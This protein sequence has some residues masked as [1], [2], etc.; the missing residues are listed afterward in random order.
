MSQINM[1]WTE[2]GARLDQAAGSLSYTGAL[3]TT[4][5][6]PQQGPFPL[7]FL[8]LPISNPTLAR[9]EVCP[10]RFRATL[11]RALA[12]SQQGMTVGLE[13]D[14][15]LRRLDNVLQ[16]S[17]LVCGVPTAHHRELTH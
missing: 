16:Q 2:L 17:E 7:P 3:P 15:S 9:A 1:V 13:E 11:F 4:S 5:P 6:A 14:S 12:W 8:L 10:T